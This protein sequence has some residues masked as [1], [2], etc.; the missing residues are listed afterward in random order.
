MP[1]I[2]VAARLDKSREVGEM[3]KVVRILITGL[4]L[5][6]LLAACSLPLS[7]SLQ[8][9]I[10][11]TPSAQLLV[12]PVDGL[13]DEPIS[14]RLTNFTPNQSVTIWA[15]FQDDIGQI[16]QAEASFVTDKYGTVDVSTQVP[17]SGSYRKADPMGLFWSA[18]PEERREG[19]V[20]APFSNLWLNPILV[21]FEARIHGAVIARTQIERLRVLPEVIRKT[22]DANE[23][24]GTFFL[25][26]GNGPF[27]CVIVVGGATGELWEEPAALLASH[28]FAALS[29]PYFKMGTLPNQLVEI[30]LEYFENAINWIE[31]QPLIDKNHIGVMGFAR[32]GEL[33]LLL[34]TTFPKIKAVVGYVPSSLVWSAYGVQGSGDQAAW[35]FRG[36]PIPFLS[37]SGTRKLT[38]KTIMNKLL[39]NGD[40]SALLDSLEQDP[41]IAQAIIP[42]EKING[43]V[44]LISGKDDRVWDSTLYA[45]LTCFRMQKRQTV[46]PCEHLSYDGAGHSISFPYIPTTVEGFQSTHPVSGKLTEIGGNTEDIATANADAWSHVLDFLDRNL[47]SSGTIGSSWLNANPHSLSSGN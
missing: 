44:L 42:V 25:P 34:G 45:D 28:G 1:G 12:Q 3:N 29:V 15:S 43:P 20:P 41:E 22:V 36:E 32:G 6:P 39:S 31:N 40:H 26:P 35:T 23:F 17:W 8:P 13:I 16:W 38:L 11:D 10:S 18:V 9:K 30:P 2:K 7:N 4:L 19:D 27:P 37:T 14:I 46:Y 5:V 21:T 33:A 47:G 24:V